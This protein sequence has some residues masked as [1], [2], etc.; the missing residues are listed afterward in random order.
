MTDAIG[1]DAKKH[2]ETI[3]HDK[4]A[5]N[6]S[7]HQD[8]P[9]LSLE[10]IEHA[11]MDETAPII[12]VGSGA[13]RLIGALL[14]A[15]YSAVTALDISEAALEVARTQLGECAGQVQWLAADVRNAQLPPYHYQIWHDRA[16]YHFLTDPADRAAYSRTLQRAVTPGGQAIIATF[17]PDGPQQCSNLDVMRYSSQ[18]LAEQLGEGF[19]LLETQAETHTTP[20]HSQQ[21]FTW[22][23][24]RVTGADERLDAGET[25]CGDLIMHIFQQMKAFA[26]GQVLEVFAHDPGAPIDIPAWCRQTG[27]RLLYHALPDT[28]GLPM[29]F[30]IQKKE[31]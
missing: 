4:A 28:K 26:P 12:D 11:A 6:V 22:C 27:N 18:S 23:R 2:W 13:T 15:G 7:W 14:D 16:V 29:K 20:W 25:A 21:Q 5:N 19:T 1:F 8:R 30:Y 9:D 10:Y 3:Y 17:A 24:F 31:D